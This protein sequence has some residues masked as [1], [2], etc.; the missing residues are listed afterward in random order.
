ML[1]GASI[2]AQKVLVQRL[3]SI[4]VRQAGAFLALSSERETV[5]DDVAPVIRLMGRVVVIC[6]ACF[7]PAAVL[8]PRRPRGA[9]DHN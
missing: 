4:P 3:L 8:L 1:S 2:Q 7:V 6:A 5:G 9:G